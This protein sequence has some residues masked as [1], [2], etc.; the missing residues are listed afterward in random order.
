VKLHDL[1]RSLPKG[2]PEGKAIEA[3][4]IDAVVDYARRNVILLPA[5]RRALDDGKQ[6][7]SIANTLLAA[8]PRAE[9]RTL[10]EG[11]EPLTLRFGQVLHEQGATVPYVYFP[12][13]CVISLLATAEDHQALEVGLVGYEGMV[14]IS[15][16]L[17]ADTSSIRA[18]V[19]ADGTAL[20]MKAAR[21]QAALSECLPLQRVLYRYAHVELARSRQ[22]V[23][24]NC[25]H[26]VEAR[27]ARWLLTM[28]DRA[29]SEEFFLTQAMVAELLGVRRATVNES[30]APLQRS[31]VINF[32]RGR[33]TILDRKSLEALACLCYARNRRQLNVR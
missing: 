9:Y 23:A 24:C 2:S 22:A 19:Q 11:F 32:C 1:L 21:F 29:G 14:G 7:A 3:G 12:V 5:A 16:V 17:G 4:E 27:F 18:V 31:G 8:L 33:I 20:R 25:F 28:G 30:A 26:A 15:L 6:E 10:L 13:D